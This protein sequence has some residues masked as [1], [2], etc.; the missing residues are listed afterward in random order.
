MF[1]RGFTLIC[2]LTVLLALFVLKIQSA[3]KKII[4]HYGNR[5]FD[6]TSFVPH[7]PGGPL[8]L[9]HANG[10]DVTEFLAGKKGIVLTEEGGRKVQHHHG[11]GA[12]NVLN[13]L[14]IKGR[15]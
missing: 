12:F 11:S 13:S 4:V 3:D 10:K 2:I 6:I 5:T 15:V 7:H 1:L 14:E 9:K 8:V